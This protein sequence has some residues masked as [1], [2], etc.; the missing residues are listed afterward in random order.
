MVPLERRLEEGILHGL[1]VRERIQ[2]GISARVNEVTFISV[3]RHMRIGRS[4]DGSR[5]R[6]SSRPDGPRR[7]ACVDWAT[8][9]CRGR[10]DGPWRSGYADWATSPPISNSIER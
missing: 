5:P 7:S 6:G 10:P 1:E 4:A 2:L 3:P 9:P 8:S